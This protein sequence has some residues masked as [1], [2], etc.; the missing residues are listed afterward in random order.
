MSVDSYSNEIDIVG[1]LTKII[2]DIQLLIILDKKGSLLS[3]LCSEDCT[4]DHDLTDFRNL[5]KLV[6]IRYRIGGFDKLLGGLETTINVFKNKT[7][8]V[9]GLQDDNIL[10]VVVPKKYENLIDT[11]N[12]IQ[13]LKHKTTNVKNS[14]SLKR[15]ASGITNFQKNQ[16]KHLPKMHMLVAANLQPEYKHIERRIYGSHKH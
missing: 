10:V 7:L 12:A 4:K 13:T 3:Y 5:A 11:L 6:S 8:F 16:K 1:K 2:P 15:E 14:T 9:R